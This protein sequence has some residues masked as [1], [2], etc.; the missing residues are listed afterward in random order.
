[1]LLIC[2]QFRH[3]PIFV[4]VGFR[5]IHC[6]LFSHILDGPNLSPPGEAWDR[7]LTAVIGLVSLAEAD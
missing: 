7:K 1:M 2:M 6:K 5:Y 3:V 4:C